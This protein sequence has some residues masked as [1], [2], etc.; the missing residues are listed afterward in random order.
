M[1]KRCERKGPTACSI[2]FLVGFIKD[3]GFRRIMLKCDDEPSTKP[4]QDALIQACAGVEVIPQGPLDGDHMAN[5]RVQ[6]AVRKV[7]RL[8]RTLWISAEQH[9]TA[10]FPCCS[11]RHEHNE[12][13]QGWKKERIETNWRME[14]ANG[15]VWRKF[16]SVNWEKVT[17][18]IIVGHHDR[19]GGVLCSTKNGVVRG[20]SWTRLT[21]N[22]AWDAANLDG[23]CGTPWQMVALE[24]KFTKKVTADKEGTGPPLPRIV[25]ERIPEVEPRRFYVLS[26]DIE[27]HHDTGG[28]PG[29][30]A[31]TSHG[32]A[33]KPHSNENRERI[34]TII[35]R[36]L[37]EKARMIAYKDSVAETQRVKERKRV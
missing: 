31:L 16:R 19:S 22:D 18:G 17:Q 35:G 7:N 12:N 30:A 27:A 20:K 14:K 1:V 2:S 24:L 3:L 28:C 25:V 10:V 33:I 9:T 34:R 32:R 11:P 36:T 4:L 23:L 8:C 29:C 21:L 6:M 37:T 15:T 13:R 5:G 26:A